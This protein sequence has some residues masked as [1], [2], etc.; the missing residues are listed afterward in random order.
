MQLSECN[1]KTPFEKIF[2][3]NQGQEELKQYEQTTV[4]KLDERIKN[5]SINAY[6]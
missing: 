4:K 5:Y 2:L 1:F 3:Q 6:N